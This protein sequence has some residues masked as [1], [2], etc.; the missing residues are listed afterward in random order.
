MENEVVFN[1]SVGIIRPETEKSVEE[2][3]KFQNKGI[4]FFY[5]YKGG[6]VPGLL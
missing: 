1:P 5:I 4:I 6:M 2:K 3:L